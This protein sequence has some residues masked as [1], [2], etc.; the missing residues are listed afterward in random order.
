ML[1]EWK[2]LL[3]SVVGMKRSRSSLTYFDSV[4]FDKGDNKRYSAEP[5]DG[6]E[7]CE[8]DVTWPSS[9]VLSRLPGA[10]STPKPILTPSIPLNI[11]NTPSCAPDSPSIAPSFV[12]LSWESVICSTPEELKSPTL[13]HP[14]PRP[15]KQSPTSSSSPTT[16]TGQETLKSMPLQD[17]MTKIGLRPSTYPFCRFLRLYPPLQTFLPLEVS[18]PRGA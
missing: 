3:F 12:P 14:P 11:R 17:F 2:F 10:V 7:S 1:K 18:P 9:P 13:H 8:E 16:N 5:F 15:S 4:N 6:G